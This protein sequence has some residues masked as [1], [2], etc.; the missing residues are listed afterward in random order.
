MARALHD[1]GLAT[2]LFDLLTESEE[3]ED[4]YSGALRFDVR[5]LARRLLGATHWY[6]SDNPDQSL[7][8]FG[9]ST[10]GAAALIAASQ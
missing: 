3:R 1:H 10:G 2:L 4:R 7:G 5:L 8:Y 9:S 6:H